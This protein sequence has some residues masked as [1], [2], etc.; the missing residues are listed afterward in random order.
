[1]YGIKNECT[2]LPACDHMVTQPLRQLIIKMDLLCLDKDKKWILPQVPILTNW[3]WLS[4]R[5]Y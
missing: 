5:L 1:M 4:Q 3:K 2:Q